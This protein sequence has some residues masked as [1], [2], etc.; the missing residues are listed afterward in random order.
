MNRFLKILANESD[1][2]FTMI[3]VI[4]AMLIIGIVA[5]FSLLFLMT[6]AAGFVTASQNN[7]LA[8]KARLA[9]TR[10]IL[11]FTDEL[12]T[13]VTLSPNVSEK[14]YA[15]YKYQLNPAKYR[16]I[17]LAGTGARKQIVIID[18]ETPVP[19]S[20]SNE[21]LIDNVS[22][23]TMIFEKCDQTE[24][25]IADDIADLCRIQ[26]SLTLYVNEKDSTTVNF[27]TTIS[28]PNRNII[29]GRLTF[30]VLKPLIFGVSKKDDDDLVIEWPFLNKEYLPS[31]FC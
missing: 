7:L 29:I 16:Q 26:I 5:G 8:Q 18:G 31:P 24:W 23:F 22:D 15:K 1:S 28:P 11:E 4:A 17:G 6:G 20:S 19:D 13:V 10:V 21:I 27:S 3:E 14:T 12:E 30:E 25:T 2:G 9:L